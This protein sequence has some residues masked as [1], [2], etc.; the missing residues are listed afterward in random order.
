M[1]SKE[2]LKLLQDMRSLHVRKNRGYAG[3]S[4][5]AWANFRESED[6]GISAFKGVLVRMSDKWIRTKNL[7]KNPKNDMVGESLKDTLMDLSAYALIGVCILEEEKHAAKL[8]KSEKRNIQN[9]AKRTHAPKNR[10]ADA[11]RKN[12]KAHRS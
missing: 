5:D 12:G 7:V 10:K 3:G 9:V 11:S 2:Y 8:Q 1:A 4:A 6:F